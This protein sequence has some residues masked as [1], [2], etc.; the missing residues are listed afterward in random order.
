MDDLGARLK[1]ARE[2]RG[3]SLRDI[4]TRTKMPVVQI[5]E[6]QRLEAD[7]V[8]VIAPDRR[9]QIVDHEIESLHFDEP[10]GRRAPIEYLLARIEDG[11]PISG[12]LDPALSLV[13]QRMIDSAVLS[14]AGKRSVPL[15]P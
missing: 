6:R 13:G 4:A 12:P 7:H 1:H 8:Y 9:L 11:A 5:G 15:V 3:V 14:A 10:G 2:V